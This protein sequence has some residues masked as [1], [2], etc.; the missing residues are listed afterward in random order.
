MHTVSR[1]ALRAVAAT[2]PNRA[3][4]ASLRQLIL[5]GVLVLGFPLRFRV[6]VPL[7]GG[8]LA[9]PLAAAAGRLLA[10]PAA[11]CRHRRTLP[12]LGTALLALAALRVR[13]LWLLLLLLRRRHQLLEG[14]HGGVV[15][16]KP[17]GCVP[18]QKQKEAF[19]L[20]VLEAL[21]C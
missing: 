5:I 20:G 6:S 2:G 11:R 12:A 3:Q 15:L 10:G 4:R 19:G 16:R 18:G 21:L 14:R 8:A 13:H 1:L 9:A 17:A 7:G